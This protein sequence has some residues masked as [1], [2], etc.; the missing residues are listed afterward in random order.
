RA[1]G[2]ATTIQMLSAPRLFSGVPSTATNAAAVQRWSCDG[3]WSRDAVRVVVGS[4]SRSGAAV[5]DT[6]QEAVRRPV[7][8]PGIGL[9]AATLGSS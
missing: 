7:G 2:I 8:C 4:C 9:V 5:D 3:L 1:L 6:A